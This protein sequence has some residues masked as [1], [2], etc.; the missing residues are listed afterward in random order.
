MA[1]Y[2]HS[3]TLDEKKCKGCTNCIKRCP[4]EAIRVRNG[5]A[6]IIK[7]RCIDCGECIRVCPYHAKS[8][9]TDNFEKIFKYKYKIAL[10]AP[11]LY[12]QFKN[13]P[14]INLILTG[15][16]KLGFDD[17]FEVSHAAEFVTSVTQKLM[18]EGLLPSPA[19][20]SACPAVMRLIRVRF[21]NLIENVVPLLAPIEIAAYIAK[22]RAIIKTNL[23]PNDIGIFF[24]TPCAAKVTCS[25]API[26]VE[27]SLID[28]S[29]AMSEIYRKLLPVMKKI[30]K[31]ESLAHSSLEGIVWA[32]N[33][34]ETA[35]LNTENYIAVDGIH[36]VIKILE[37]LEGERLDN[38]EFVEASACVGGCIGGP[39]T[40]E[41]PF[42]ARTRISNVLENTIVSMPDFSWQEVPTSLARWTSP[43]EFEPVLNLDDNM[44]IAMQKMKQMEAINEELP[45]L[46]CGSC[47]APSCHALAEDIVRGYA[48]ETDCVFKL[49]ER[50]T[51]LAKEMV[52]LESMA[53]GQG[54][55]MGEDDENK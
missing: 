18:A 17:V 25:Y 33:G 1:K 21:P 23:N 5:K 48:K 24:I 37:E 9:I 15:L 50:V 3:V 14:D 8:A 39:L 53:W 51:M 38:V 28:G 44:L 47:G 40:V 36:N 30:D 7:D 4:T 12:V 54:N 19:I 11:S 20:S 29:I 22:E 43:M 49:R 42:V 46:D 10:P 16:K 26:G 6:K 35:G 34:G 52:Q 45:K 27:S 2:F 31:V 55:G 32:K 41:N 13:K